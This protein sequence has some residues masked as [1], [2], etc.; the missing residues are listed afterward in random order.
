MCLKFK[1]CGVGLGVIQVLGVGCNV[2]VFRIV[3]I[4]CVGIRVQR[5]KYPKGLGVPFSGLSLV[6]V[7]GFV[8][9][10]RR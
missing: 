1:V 6:R 3:C 8:Y 7:L 5:S 4:F 10:L 2:L 9:L